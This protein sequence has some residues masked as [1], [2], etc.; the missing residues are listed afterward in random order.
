MKVEFSDHALAQLGNRPRIKREMVLEAIN[1]P[2]AA[3]V[4]YRQRSLYRKHFGDETLEVV[5]V[6][7]DDT[8]VVIT[9]YFL[10][11]NP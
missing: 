5:T 11:E 6:N 1:S 10:D 2:D 3:T 8:I 9:Q 4:S 7:G